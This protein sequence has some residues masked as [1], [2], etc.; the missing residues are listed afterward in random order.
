VAVEHGRRFVLRVDHDGHCRDVRGMHQTA[1]QGIHQ[2]PRAAALPLELLAHRQPSDQGH[3]QLR[4]A[5]QLLGHVGSDVHDVDDRRR[6]RAIAEHVGTGWFDQHKRRGDMLL[7]VL[8]GLLT[9]VAIERFSAAG[10][11]GA[12]P[13]WPWC[14]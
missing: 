14:A 9:R 10:E 13:A 8:P 4:I 7:S 5:R 3:R 12:R 6:Q 2:Q 1:I 11:A